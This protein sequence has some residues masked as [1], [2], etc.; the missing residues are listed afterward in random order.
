MEKLAVAPEPSGKFI[1]EPQARMACARA[2]VD[3]E[4][5]PRHQWL[6]VLHL[7]RQDPLVREGARQGAPFQTFGR[8]SAACNKRFH[9]D[10]LP[11]VLLLP[12][13]LSRLL[14]PLL[15]LLLLLLLLVDR[16]DGRHVVFGKVL[17]G[18]DVV[19]KV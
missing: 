7:H 8:L 19:R 11:N 15:P 16:L 13:R 17:E 1:T 2:C 3:G 12:R 14:L 18:M 6:P 9:L 4:R 10:L 5:G